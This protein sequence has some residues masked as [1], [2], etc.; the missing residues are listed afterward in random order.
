MS[1]TIAGR[2]IKNEY[3]AIGTILSTIG[4]AVASSSGGDKKATSSA[5]VPIA[6]DTSI[7]AG[8]SEED[9]FIRQFVAEAEKDEKKH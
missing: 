6:N 2:V 8:T 9:A 4:I 3:I 7:S 1:Y 5:P